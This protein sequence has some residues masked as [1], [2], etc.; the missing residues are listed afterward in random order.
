M[1]AKRNRNGKEQFPALRTLSPLFLLVCKAGNCG[2]Y[3]GAAVRG[4]RFDLSGF[5]IPARGFVMDGPAE[6]CFFHDFSPDMDC[7]T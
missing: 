2:D 5:Q 3:A 4:E 1:K 7:E 6:S